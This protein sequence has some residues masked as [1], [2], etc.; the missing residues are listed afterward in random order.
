MA[1][2]ALPPL[3]RAL[4][5]GAVALLCGVL[6]LAALQRKL[7]FFPQVA[8]EADV[9]R[10]GADVGA[11]PWRPGGEV[12]GWR[13]SRPSA[14]GRLLA[15]HGNA[16]MAVERAYMAQAFG[17]DFEVTVVEYPGFGARPGDPGEAAFF[18]AAE[19]AFDALR[20]EDPA[21]PVTVLGE[22][23]GSGAAC[24]LAQVR[25]E[26]LAG[27]ILVTPFDRLAGPAGH[28]FPWLPVSMILRDRFEN[29]RALTD[30][31]GR[32]AFVLAGR[33]TVVPP[34][35]GQ[36]L[37]DAYRG[38]KRLWVDAGADHNE[39]PWDRRAPLWAEIAAFLRAG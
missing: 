12:Q 25:G 37:H 24:H 6:M 38:A 35:F 17:A 29:D 34:K 9:A 30:F 11:T 36:A 19:S 15:F 21:R 2:L 39:L 31:R 33:D 18:A 20:A 4:L 14:T 23:I 26:H 22:S 7:M 16:G 10:L 5:V 27:L 28:H 13:F 32:V 1:H 8:T 3:R